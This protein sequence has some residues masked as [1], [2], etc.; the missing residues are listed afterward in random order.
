MALALLRPG[1]ATND[2]IGAALW[3]DGPPATANKVIQG[4]VSRL[5]ALLGGELIETVENGYRLSPSFVTDAARFERETLR[6]RELLELGQADRA[7]YALDQ[8]LSTWTGP[9]FAEIAHWPP[10]EAENTRA[11]RTHVRAEEL[12]VD[13]LT[14]AG[15]WE[16]AIPLAAAGVDAEPLREHRWAQL[17]LAEYRSGNQA[18]ALDAIRRCRAVLR[19]ELG[20][21]PGEE[22]TRLQDAILAQDPDLEPA[23][24]ERVAGEDVCPWPGLSAYDVRDGDSFFGRDAEIAEALDVLDARGTLTVAGPSGIGKSSFLR[25]GIAAALH[26]RGRTVLVITPG[27]DPPTPDHDLVVLDQAEELLSLPDETRTAVLTA[28]A[29]HRGQLVLGVRGDAVTA[30]A[31]LPTLT[32]TVEQG[33]FVLSG[34]TDEGVRAAIESPAAQHGLVVEPGLVDVVLRDL[35]DQPGALPLFSHALAETWAHR[36]GRS[37]TVEAYRAGGGVHG[38]VAR[39]AERLYVTA[40]EPDRE[41]IRSLL[42]RMVAEGSGRRLRMPLGDLAPEQ[43][44]VLGPLVSARLLTV[45]EDDVALTHE[46]L[47]GAW[48]RLAGWLDEDTE[49]RRFLRHLAAA[50]RAWREMARPDSELYRGSRLASVLSWTDHAHPVLTEE[51]HEFLAAAERRE[52]A[53]ADA[54]A[55]HARRQARANRRLRALAVLL[56]LVLVV[57]AAAAGL[58]VARGRQADHSAQQARASALSA[59]ARRVGALALTTDEPQQ[60]L[61]LAAAA[62]KLSP[63]VDTLRTL[64]ESIAQR[65]QLVGTS[66]IESADLLGDVVAVGDRVM[67]TDQRHVLHV[68]DTRLREVAQQAVGR[69]RAEAMPVQMAA[70]GDLIA[71][72]APS[73]DELPIRLLDAHTLQP[74]AVQLTGWPYDDVAVMDLAFAGDGSRLSAFVDHITIRNEEEGD[75]WWDRARLLTWDVRTGRL[76]GPPIRYPDI[77][78]GLGLS[79]HGDTVVTSNPPTAYDVTTGRRLWTGDGGGGSAPLSGHLVA[80]GNDSGVQLLDVRTGEQRRSLTVAGGVQQIRFA[81]DGRTVAASVDDGTLLVWET[82]TGSLVGR[83][84]PGSRQVQGVAFAPDGRTLYTGLADVHELQ[85]WDLAGAATYLR[86]LPSP[87]PENPDPTGNSWLSPDASRFAQFQLGGLEAGRSHSLTLVDVDSGR[88]VH[89][90]LMDDSVRSTGAWSP[91]SARFALGRA[92]GW[93]QVWDGATGHEVGRSAPLRG[94]VTGVGWA[95][96][97]RLALADSLGNA[98]LLDARTMTALHPP[99]RLPGP[100]YGLAAAADGR[101]AVVMTSTGKDLPGYALEAT[102]WFELD[103]A[104]GTVVRQGRTPVAHTGDLAVTPDG[105]RL[106]LIGARGEVA[107]V[108]LRTGRPVRQPTP[109]LRGDGSWLALSPDGRRVVV[110]SSAQDAGLY[111]VG[112]GELLGR[113]Q[114]PDGEA[115][116]TVAFAADGTVRLLTV[117]GHLY[118]WDPDISTAVA[119]A[120]SVAG[121]D[122]T[123]P[124]WRDAFGSIRQRPVC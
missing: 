4:C 84:A 57:A 120:C 94:H 10:A 90:R 97:D 27:G 45:D 59:A 81:P 49:S 119:H 37:L 35:Q 56:S 11:I 79:E 21:D 17:A 23:P 89:P 88:V 9:P 121:R 29:R 16:R 122:L 47:V 123:V 78:S 22:V 113:V 8:A 82:R 68:M 91:D 36:E 20:L 40:S 30:V 60:S 76:V 2:Q 103:L 64:T 117:N 106:V 7:A 24:E 118:R 66:V 98:V 26:A 44:A 69:P 116:P 54:A 63:S 86:R 6:G 43:R 92:N 124:E 85:R 38:A 73:M 114:L 71:V 77:W 32:R 12:R 53:E 96:D 80:T 15:R 112:T 5:R 14:A 61:L 34:L 108:D 67:V 83:L 95:G 107:V 99:M 105:R 75:G 110:G 109:S 87:V 50:A 42:V 104:T 100:L 70:A 39:T 25:A 13:A 115:S 1:V 48:P 33:L 111:D 18:G 55:E 93:V 72:A 41:L 58:A 52:H 101:T 65:P 28:L 46:A 31:A 62:A 3:P 19:E 51:E 74:A 102:R